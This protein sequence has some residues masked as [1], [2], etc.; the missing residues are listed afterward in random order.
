MPLKTF[1]SVPKFSL[2]LPFNFSNYKK[3]GSAVLKSFT[4]AAL[5]A[6]DDDDDSDDDDV[7]VDDDDDN[8]GDNDEFHLCCPLSFLDG[9]LGFSLSLTTKKII[10]M[11]MLLIML[12]LMLLMMLMLM[13]C[14]L[15]KPSPN[16]TAVIVCC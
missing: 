9:S 10:M 4:C 1:F 11:L 12:V 3:Y 14:R 7:D 13:S 8:N 2:V 6:D 16:K 15:G 5:S